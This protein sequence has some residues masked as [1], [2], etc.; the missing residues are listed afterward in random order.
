VLWRLYERFPSIQNHFKDVHVLQ[1]W[2]SAPYFLNTTKKQV[3][4][5]EDLKG[6]KIRVTGGPPTEQMK[7]LGGI[8]VMVPMPDNYLSLDKGVIDGIA[9]PWEPFHGF[10]LYEVIKYNTLVPLHVTYFSMAMNKQKWESLPKDVQDAIRN[11]S[12]LEGSKFWG[13]NFFDTAEA[14]VMELTK[15]GGYQMVKY[16]LPPEEVERWT[17]VAGI[18]LWKEWV[19]KMEGKGYTDAQRIFDTALDL[20]KK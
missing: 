3:K 20:L 9:I 12:G 16:T 15:K 14:G 2:T 6:L 10:R 13:R 18:P 5:L 7:A 11:V 1:L 19:K 17:N 8:P 4:T